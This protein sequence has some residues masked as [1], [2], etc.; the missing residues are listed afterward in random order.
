MNKLLPPK[1][2]FGLYVIDTKAIQ[3]NYNSGMQYVMCYADSYEIQDSGAITF[4]QA[5]SD[6]DKKYKVPVL[7]YPSGKWDA[8]VLLD[9]Q[10]EFP[11]FK[12]FSSVSSN[13]LETN[14]DREDNHRNTHQRHGS[15]YNNQQQTNLN[16]P[17]QV[18]SG[19]LPGVNQMLSGQEFKKQKEEWIENEIKNFVKDVELFNTEEFLEVI[20]KSPNNRTF[21]AV[22]SDVEWAASKLIR[23]KVIMSRKFAVPHIQKTLALILP[24]IMRRQWDGKMAPILQILQ[25]REETKNVTAIDLAV[26]MVQNN[27]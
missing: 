10:N 21:K 11:A 20:Q 5:L 12:G 22:E 7:T 25:E 8:C 4:Y 13:S 2:R 19:N 23:N 15:G 9:D 1:L 3:K 27:Y 18:G 26:W 16:Q 17:Q 24:D 6:G 14:E